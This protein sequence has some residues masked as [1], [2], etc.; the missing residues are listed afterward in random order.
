VRPG[1]RRRHGATSAQADDL[2]AIRAL[3]SRIALATDSAD[4]PAFE[5]C[6]VP[7]AH[8]DY[9]DLGVGPIEQLAAAI[10]ESQ[11]RYLGTMNLVGTHHATV[12][13]ERAR[14]ETYVVSHH[15]RRDEGQSFDD[16][17]GT[18]Y[19]DELVRMPEGWKIARRVA[20]LQWF[21]SDPVEGG[22]I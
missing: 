15:F 7:G 18:R 13:G 14:S 19:S 16:Q 2:L 9:G 4:W 8:A 10:R 1:E 20:R 5:A 11:A 22:W 12:S 17:A 3:A 21:R 6:F